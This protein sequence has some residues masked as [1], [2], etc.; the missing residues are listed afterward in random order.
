MGSGA[1]GTLA[2]GDNMQQE[3]RY[4][5]CE[6]EPCKEVAERIHPIDRAGFHS[7]LQLDPDSPPGDLEK[8]DAGC[9]K[10]FGASIKTGRAYYPGCKPGIC[11]VPVIFLLKIYKRF[12]SPLLPPCCRFYPSCSV[13]GMTALRVHGLW[14]G[15]LLTLWRVF[16]CN[17]FFRGGYDPVPPKGAWC[18]LSS[19]KEKSL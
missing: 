4:T 19:D 8:E 9:E 16:R 2:F 15:S 12:I 17:P 1:G 7:S 13:Y 3:I 10:F 5:G 11:A 18:P 14:K 6:T